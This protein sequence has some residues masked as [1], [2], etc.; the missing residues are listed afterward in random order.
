VPSQH[1]SP[2]PSPPPPSPPPGIAI[3][4]S[5]T[6]SNNQVDFSEQYAALDRSKARIIVLFCQA[7]DGGRFMRGAYEVGI[8]GP[9][10]M[11]IGSDAVT[12]SDTW[13]LNDVM[14]DPTLRL[15]V[16]KGFIGLSPSIGIDTPVYDAYMDR[17]RAV[18]PTTGDGTNCNLATDDDITA[19]TPT[20]I[21]AQD[22]D[23]NASTPL[24]CGGNDNQDEGS[25]APYAYDAVYAIAHAL[26]HLIESEQKT[27]IV[28]AEL[29]DALITHVDFT[30]VTGRINMH[31]A[32]SHP[33]RL[34]HGDRRVG[35]AYDV[36]NYGDNINEL[37]RVATWTPGDPDFVQRWTQLENFTY[38][39]VD[40]SLPIDVVQMPD[41]DDTLL[42]TLIA[43][44]VVLGAVVSTVACVGTWRGIKFLRKALKSHRLQM[45]AKKKRCRQ[46]VT[47]S[48]TMQ[49]SCY[50]ITFENMKQMKSL[51][52]HEIARDSGW[53]TVIDTYDDLVDLVNAKPVVF[54][55]HRARPHGPH[56]APRQGCAEAWVVTYDSSTHD[57]L[58]PPFHRM[59]LMAPPRPRPA[60]VQPDDRGMRDHLHRQGI[61][62][63]G[64]LLLYRVRL[65]ALRLS[66]ATMASCQLVLRRAASTP[67]MFPAAQLLLH[68]AEKRQLASAGHQ[69]ARSH[70]VAHAV[71]LRHRAN[72]RA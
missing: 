23:D 22:H 44:T 47:T 51:Q 43:I 7:S 17:V 37:Q 14:T 50:L 16:M 11:W 6:L 46:A 20:Y 54:F 13:L 21:W 33:D 15:A 62:P 57:S 58:H 42:S 8:G 59:A 67:T 39:T 4:A 65:E 9:G 24:A 48:V 71:L 45:E 61:R 25:Y 40:N 35:I 52:S 32:S 29:Y 70:L 12:K 5:V 34:Y 68:T 18:P 72:E 49:S 2:H 36:Y 10:Y 1:P 19:A 31:D 60:P 64:P 56:A 53:L 28:G 41:D 66:R 69:H 26:H 63:R 55:S 3:L 38:S 30:S 27:H